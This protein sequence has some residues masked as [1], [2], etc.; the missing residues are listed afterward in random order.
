MSKDSLYNTFINRV[1]DNL[2]II[3]CMSPVGEAFRSR[4]RQFPSLINCCTIDWYMEWPAEALNS[5]SER[6]L[7]GIELGSDDV[8]QAVASMCVDIHVSVTKTS[9]AFYNELR[10]RF[11]VTPK[12][13]LDL[14]HLYTSLLD[15]KRTKLGGA[16]D[17]LLNGLQKLD[18]TNALVAAMKIELGELQPV[19]KEKAA[20]TE[21]LLVQ[22]AGDKE[23]AALVETAVAAEEAVATKQAEETKLI[24]ASA[25]ADLDEA[26][27]A[28]ESAVKSLNALNKADIVE[29][30][31]FPKPP[32]LVTGTRR[33]RCWAKAT[34]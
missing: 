18:E 4:C 16:R 3:L 33:R 21:I 12:S 6:F 11:Y 19:L 13:Y 23:E 32:P 26:M 2:H 31:G 1:R 9:E 5:V 8:R 25:Q 34:S 27:P 7:S 22:V 14:I 29:V 28:L 24:A 17:R 10:R 30:K 20:A 15:E